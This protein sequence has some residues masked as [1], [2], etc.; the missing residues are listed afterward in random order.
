MKYPNEILNQV[1]KPARYT[2]GEWNSIVKDWK[3]T[4]IRI[5]L[6]YPEIYEIGMSNLALPILYEILNRQPDVLAERVYAPWVD[7]EAIMRRRNIPLF[8]LESRQ[9]LKEFNIIGFS[10]GYELTYTNV[11]NILD[12]AQIPL[13]SSSR[14]D[15]H[16]LI[17]AGGSCALNP[18]PLADFID[19]FVIGEGE[20]II[21]ELLEVFREYRR[22][23]KTL[24]K[25]SAR[26]AGIYVPSFYCVDYNKDGSIN[27]ILPQIAEAKPK[28]NRRIV[29]RLPFPVTSPI[30]PYIE[31]VH[32]RGSV[33]IQR[34]CTRGCRFCQAGIIYRP[35][36]ERPHKDVVTAAGELLKNCGYSEIS[37]LSLSSGDYSDI[38]KL[39]TRLSQQ[40]YGDNLTFSFPSLRMDSSVIK[41]LDL[42]PA[43]RRPTLTFAPEAG[44]EKL[45]RIINKGIS[46]ETIL[47]TLAFVLDKGWTKIKL[48]FMIGLPGETL[49]DIYSIVELMTKIRRLGGKIRLH[50][51]VSILVPKPHTPCQWL[52]QETE[53]QL[54]PK[55]AI[56]KK[57]LSRL[58]A[59]FSWADPK[60][61]QL[62]AALSRGDRRLG[63]VIHYAWQTGCKFDAWNEYFDYHKWLDAFQQF[64]LHP[65]F[66]ANRERALDETLSWSHI[67]TGVNLEFL[68]REYHNMWQE[69]ETPDCRYGKCHACG[70]NDGQAKKC[71]MA[72]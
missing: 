36:R 26:L 43:R 2:G 1:T 5:A 47:N 31:V 28:I 18:E 24:L 42:L 17:I 33:E 7:M 11:L 71:P 3:T 59:G 58:K 12:L 45:R 10:L 35:V 8:S 69:K 65:S 39:I 37:L 68:Q 64:G 6:C 16:P 13:F 44:S 61:S 15:S 20:E 55:Y 25:Q 48:Y 72:S 52:A 22:D 21:L 54:L 23:K 9:A 41:L 38:D 34:G 57:E 29:T 19:L 67:D 14:G 63:Q 30:V 70:L 53:E 46:E 50:I 60:T 27:S 66:Y 40:F 62:E 4:P 32:D 49:E 56:L 51:S